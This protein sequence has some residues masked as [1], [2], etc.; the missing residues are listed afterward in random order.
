MESRHDSQ[1]TLYT[2]LPPFSVYRYTRIPQILSPFLYSVVG[3]QYSTAEFPNRV[4][5]SYRV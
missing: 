3:N 2:R 1:F 5:L 4:Q